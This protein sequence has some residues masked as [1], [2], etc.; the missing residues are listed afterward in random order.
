M[1][2]ISTLQDE[3]YCLIKPHL[4]DPFGIFLEKLKQIDGNYLWAIRTTSGFCLNKSHDFEEE[5][6]MKFRDESFRQRC[7]FQSKDEALNFWKL[8]KT[9][10]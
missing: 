6:D 8:F 9:K 10:D 1:F 5:P 7:R 3:I 4:A 2:N